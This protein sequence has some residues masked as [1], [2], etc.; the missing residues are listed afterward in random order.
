MVELQPAEP[1]P[2]TAV[3]GERVLPPS[4]HLCRGTLS[5]NHGFVKVQPGLSGRVA[6]KP[7]G[8]ARSG[9]DRL[10]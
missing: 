9:I 3:V 8:V 10:S 6:E 2:N 7:V 4:Q 5:A 1:K